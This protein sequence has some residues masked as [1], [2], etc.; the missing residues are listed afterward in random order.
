MSQYI[1][2]LSDDKATPPFLDFI[3]N[4]DFIKKV[5]HLKALANDDWAKPGR[6]AIDEEFEQMIVRAEKSKSLSLSEAKKMT[7]KRFD[8]WQHMNSK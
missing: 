3:R 6:P 1:L 2:T 8:E 5:E 4:L 7:R